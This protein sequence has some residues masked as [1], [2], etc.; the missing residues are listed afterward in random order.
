[1]KSELRVDCLLVLL[2]RKLYKTFD[3]EQQDKFY[4]RETFE[5]GIQECYYNGFLL[6]GERWGSALNTTRKN[7]NLY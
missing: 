7:E 3:E 1:M 6:W 5:I 4:S 2:K